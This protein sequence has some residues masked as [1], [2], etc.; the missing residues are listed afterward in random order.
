ML[1]FHEVILEADGGAAMREPANGGNRQT[2]YK[3]L[4]F[5]A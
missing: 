2:N 5:T 3:P 4:R 1:A